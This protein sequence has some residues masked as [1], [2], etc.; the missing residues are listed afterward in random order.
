MFS[1]MRK[2]KNR[3]AQIKELKVDTLKKIDE[4]SESVKKVKKILDDPD[5]TL[6]IYY[7]TRRKGK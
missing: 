7:A 6:Q 5:I 2:K 4:A 1:F 3:E